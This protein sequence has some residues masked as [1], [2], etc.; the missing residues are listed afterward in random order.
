MREYEYDVA[1]SFAGEDRQHV[2]ALA[3]LLENNGYKVF[4]DKYERSQLWGKNLYTHLSSVY[5]DKARYCVPFLSEHYARKLWANHE[6]ESAQARAFEE[7]EEYILPVRLDDTEIPGILGTVGYLD[8]H[9]MSIEGIYQALTEKLSDS[10]SQQT[11]APSTSPIVE[12]TSIEFSLLG[13]EDGKLYFFPLQDVRRDST[14]MSLELLPESP[15]NVA[16]LR[17]LQDKLSNRFSN[18][19]PLACAYREYASW[20]TPHDIVETSSHWEI[21]FNSDTRR[22]NY[23]PFNEMTVNGIPPEEIAKMRA[24]RI[25]LDEKLEDANPGLSQNYAF[26]QMALEMYIRGMSSSSHEPQLQITESEIPKLYQQLRQTP[27]RF[28]KF[29]RLTSIL[30]LKLSNTIENVLQLDLE[31]LGPTQL[32]VRFKGIRPKFYSNVDP[33]TIEFEGICPLSE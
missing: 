19:T 3:E 5:K 22:H 27:E 29:A 26:D 18:S 20:V 4:Y 1:L 17:T 23:D 8:L 28:K 14:E 30:Y 33:S 12:D 9:S 25:L 24:R 15:E 13:S 11:T 32:Q 6:L 7:N 21:R 10:P 31:L 2:E 16:F